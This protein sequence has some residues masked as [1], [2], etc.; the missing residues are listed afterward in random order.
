[1]QKKPFP[2]RKYIS[3]RQPP[4]DGNDRVRIILFA[5]QCTPQETILFARTTGHGSQKCT[6]KILYLIY[7]G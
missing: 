1:M 6:H 4:L 7:Y 3:R 5:E 2:I